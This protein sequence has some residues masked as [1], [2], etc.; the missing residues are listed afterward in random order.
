MN[1]DVPLR[2]LPAP[3]AVTAGYWE[4][5]ARG[6]LAI[7]RCDACGRWIHT[8]AVLCPAC[9]GTALA[10]HDVSARG[11]VHSHTTLTAAPAAGFAA[12]LP[13]VIVIV[14]LDEAAGLFVSANLIG[15]GAPDVRIGD[16]V[17]AVFERVTDDV[18]LPQFTLSREDAA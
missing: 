9:G 3:D 18:T 5:A 4:A 8:P 14:E 1:D 15:D 2:P 7:Q 16:R 10:F 13:L 6:A 11:R 12:L 17:H